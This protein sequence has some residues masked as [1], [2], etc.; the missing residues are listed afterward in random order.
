MPFVSWFAA[1]AAG[2]AISAAKAARNFGQQCEYCQGLQ[3]PVAAKLECLALSLS[4]Q[5]ASRSRGYLERAA[6]VMPRECAHKKEDQK[7]LFRV[8]FHN[9]CFDG[10]C[11]A[12]LFTRFHRECFGTASEYA[13]TGLMH[14]AGAQFDEAEFS[15]DENAIVD[16]KYSPS[17]KITWWFDHHQSAFASNDDRAHFERERAQ[18]A[19]NPRKFFDPLYTSCTGLI[20]DVARNSFGF[21]PAGLDDLLH[22]ADIID[23]AKFESAE[24]AVRLAQPAL[25]LMTVI[26][27][28]SD[29]AFI[30][31]LIPL[32]TAQP[33]ADTLQ[34]DF[35]Q[36]E[37]Q[38]RLQKHERD[39]ELLR[40]RVAED[41]GV[42]T[43]DI[44]DQP[45]EGYSKFIPYYLLPEAV[46]VVGLSRSSFRVKISVGTNPWTTIPSQDLANIAAICER[47][48]G[49]GHARVG[50]ISVPV[51]RADEARRIAAEVTAE[52]KALNQRNALPGNAPSPLLSG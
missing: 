35:V 10:A 46:Y 12:S 11:S 5:R 31:R 32:L 22:W 6:N 29:P 51:D 4:S 45:T 37:L 17:E 52:L 39:I 41:R 44:T 34:Q 26:E 2:I 16:F 8:L 3:Y 40:S 49:G 14:R 9:N 23:G 47:Y 15:G 1:S 48:G 24:S 50:A 7:L 21:D 38:P 18:N 28:T 36:Q 43:F 30:P 13:Y 27:S 19:A 33:L 25:K 42:I 20:A